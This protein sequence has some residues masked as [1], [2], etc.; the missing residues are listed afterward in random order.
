MQE[1]SELEEDKLFAISVQFECPAKWSKM[2]GD[3][4]IRFCNACQKNVYNVA[5]M[6]KM[7]AL[8]LISQNEGELCLRLYKRRDGT[9]ITS[10][11][12]ATVE[13]WRFKTKYPFLA[14]A[15]A[16][17]SSALLALLP[18]LGPAFLTVQTGVGPMMPAS[19]QNSVASTPAEI[20]TV[21]EQKQEKLAISESFRSFLQSIGMFR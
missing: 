12:I 15:N 5:K 6:S 8:N 16:C 21:T 17:L 18:I 9:V 4:K 2:K 1:P 19:E 3:D 14:M 10:D 20:P 7:E 11:C 13:K